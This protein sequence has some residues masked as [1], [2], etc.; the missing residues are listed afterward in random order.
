MVGSLIA[1]IVI[2][3]SC[4]V[5]HYLVK[6]IESLF[7]AHML[8]LFVIRIVFAQK[9]FRGRFKP[10]QHFLYVFFVAQKLFHAINA[11]HR[12]RFIRAQ[13]WVEEVNLAQVFAAILANVVDFRFFIIVSHFGTPPLFSIMIISYTYTLVKC[14]YIFFL[15]KFL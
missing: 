7:F 8:V 9:L 1:V 5:K 11:I 10:I 3:V 12:V 4:A 14:F 13:P 6:R 15:A 2:F